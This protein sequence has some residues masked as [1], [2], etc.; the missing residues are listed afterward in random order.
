MTQHAP[1]GSGPASGTAELPTTVAQHFARQVIAT[2]TV[3]GWLHDL[4]RRVGYQAHI[5]V[6]CARRL[7]MADVQAY[8][9]HTITKADEPGQYQQL[10]DLYDDAEFAVKY[11]SDGS[12]ESTLI[13]WDC[14][15]GGADAV[16]QSILTGYQIVMVRH[17][18]PQNLDTVDAIV[19]GMPED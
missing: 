9:T 18:D 19:V 12:L 5:A 3:A 11:L 7:P 6:V 14:L 15:L 10:T 16:R 13:G 4:W 17:I 1:K 2:E 8:Q